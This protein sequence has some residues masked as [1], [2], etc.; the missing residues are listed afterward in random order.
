V[1]VSGLETKNSVS[2]KLDF[3]YRR[4]AVGRHTEMLVEAGCMR[5]EGEHTDWARVGKGFVVV[6]MVSGLEYTVNATVGM[7]PEVEKMGSE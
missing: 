7:G 5:L 4:A 2:E 1:V 3:A 6:Q